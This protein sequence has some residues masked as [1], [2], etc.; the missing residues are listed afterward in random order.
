LET[1]SCYEPL[2][3]WVLELQA[4]A[5]KSIIWLHSSFLKKIGFFNLFILRQSLNM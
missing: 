5:M 4:C 2:A 1:V 3:S